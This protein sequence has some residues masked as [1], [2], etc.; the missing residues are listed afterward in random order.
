MADDNLCGHVNKQ[1]RVKII[2]FRHDMLAKQTTKLFQI[3]KLLSLILV[4]L[5][6]MK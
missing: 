5:H 1:S 3:K 6:S 2:R 4:L